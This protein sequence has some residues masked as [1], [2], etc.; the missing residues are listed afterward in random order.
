MKKLLWIGD[1]IAPTGFARVSEAVL[2]ELTRS[3]YVHGEPNTLG[4][5]WDV[6]QLAIN[7]WG[8]PQTK[9]PWR[10]YPAGAASP[11]LLGVARLARIY[12]KEQPDLVCALGDPWIVTAYLQ[13]LPGDAKVVAYMP[14]DAPN[15]WVAPDLNRL[16]L[17]IAYT[18]FGARE[19]RLGG[20]VG[21]MTIIPHGVDLQ[22]FHPEDR[23]AAR[24]ALEFD[25]LGIGPDAFI[26]GNVNRNQ[27]RKRLDLSIAYF[28]QWWHAR[29][30]PPEAY[31]LLH[32][33]L[34]D[35]SGWN[36]PALAKYFGIDKQIIFTGSQTLTTFSPSE[37]LC[38][39]YNAC[40]VGINTAL[41][42]GWG[43][44][45]MEFAACSIP[46]ILPRNGALPE[47]A[48][49]LFVP[50]TNIQVQPG[51]GAPLTIGQVMD[52]DG[53]V[54]ALNTLY[55][56]PDLCA[57]LGNEGEDRVHEPRFQWAR[58]GAQFEAAFREVIG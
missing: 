52:P 12:E 9:L 23:G 36:L 7:Y 32:C 30:N 48:K 49:A 16:D 10:L 46:Q 20:Y 3:F 8:D 53:F 41:G 31:L 22:E 15:Q 21:P 44:T 4:Q 56:D 34:D 43:L 14:V 24:R 27:V 45:A 42:E 25:A 33:A 50:C 2:H 54:T 38:H 39:V 5:T 51:M 29:G 37:R 26:V 40:N 35:H 57:A 13:Q 19:L 55:A 18:S 1:A 11:D 6:A 28:A 58:I 47:W 17:A